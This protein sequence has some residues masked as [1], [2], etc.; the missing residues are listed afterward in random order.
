LNACAN[1]GRFSVELVWNGF[2]YGLHEFMQYVDGS[3]D[4]FNKCNADTS[5][6]LWIDDFFRQLGIEIT[7]MLTVFWC[8]PGKDFSDGLVEIRNDAKIV[9]MIGAVKDNN[10]ITLYVDH[11]SFVK[12][13]R[14]DVLRHGRQEMAAFQ[15]DQENNGDHLVSENSQAE[16]AAFQ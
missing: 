12:G 9:E 8:L 10:V 2:F 6:I 7:E 5:S 1:P 3:V 4:F 14:S 11:T 16:E 13:L 15:Q